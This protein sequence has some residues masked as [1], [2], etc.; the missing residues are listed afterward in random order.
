MQYTSLWSLSIPLISLLIA[1][2]VFIGING[3]KYGFYNCA[4]IICIVFS[5]LKSIGFIIIIIAILASQEFLQK[6]IDEINKDKTKDKNNLNIKDYKI[7]LIIIFLLYIFFS[8]IE[9]CVL[10]GYDRRVK[11]NCEGITVR[12]IKSSID[13]PLFR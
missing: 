3:K 6:L 1:I 11:Y 8:W 2:F 9:S 13:Q 12:N 10:M 5:V 4:K 7:T